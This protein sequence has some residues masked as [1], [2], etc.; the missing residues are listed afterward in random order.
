I[1]RLLSENRIREVDKMLCDVIE[2]AKLE[3]E[4]LILKGK[5]EGKLEGKLDVARNM[6]IEKIPIDVVAKTT[7]LLREQI[8]EIDF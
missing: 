7:G 6:L 2:Y 4:E 5:L 1:Q 8:E 3:K